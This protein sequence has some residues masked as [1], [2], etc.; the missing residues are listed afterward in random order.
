MK[1][2]KLR[3]TGLCEGNSPGTG[4]LPTQRASNAENISFDDVIMQVT[5]STHTVYHVYICI[6]VYKYIHTYLLV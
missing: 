4:E 6:Y 5:N 1:T 3:V 2:S